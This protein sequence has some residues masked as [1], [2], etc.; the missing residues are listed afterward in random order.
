M[1]PLRPSQLSATKGTALEMSS[2]SPRVTLDRHPPELA[3]TLLALAMAFLLT[4]GGGLCFSLAEPTT[5]TSPPEL[6]D[7]GSHLS[8]PVVTTA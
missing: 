6:S 1:L 5:L 7:E 3:D 2:S 4:L 8:L